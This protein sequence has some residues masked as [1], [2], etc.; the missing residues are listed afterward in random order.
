M[1]VQRIHRR[2]A[3]RSGGYGLN[4]GGGVLGERGASPIGMVDYAS[5]GAIPLIPV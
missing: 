2:L 5:L 3:V 1:H 4:R